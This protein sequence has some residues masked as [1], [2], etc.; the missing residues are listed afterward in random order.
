MPGR[1]QAAKR[2]KRANTNK[3]MDRLTYSP[4]KHKQKYTRN[5]RGKLQSKP[6]VLVTPTPASSSIRF[7]SM[8]INGLDMEAN[9][10]IEELIAKKRFDVISH[11]TSANIKIKYLNRY[12]R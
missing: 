8:N 12:W 7:G 1:S 9:W 11:Y 5:L 10:A 4:N 6:V 2:V 3:I